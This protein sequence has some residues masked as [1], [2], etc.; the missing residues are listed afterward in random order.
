MSERVEYLCVMPGATLAPP[1]IQVP[2]RTVV[3]VEAE[4]TPAWQELA[5]NW[6]VKSGCLFMMAWGEKCSSWDDSVDIANLEAFNY[7]EIPEDKFIITTWHS[8]EPLTEVFRFSKNL[9]FHP[10]VT[11]ESTLL[12]HISV[13]NKEH[14][15][16]QAFLEA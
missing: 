1:T 12:F 3:I 8:N 15:L 13:Q 6:L 14:E 11:L 10:K 2:I 9:A 7:A 5:S 16:L 4:V